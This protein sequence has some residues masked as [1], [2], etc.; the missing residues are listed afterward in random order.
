MSSTAKKTGKITAKIKHT[1][2]GKPPRIRPEL[3]PG[4]AIYGRFADREYVMI[5]VEDF[6]EWY[7]DTVDGAVA[8]YIERLEEPGIPEENMLAKVRR[9]KSVI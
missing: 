6:G 2:A 8:D 4:T 9:A 5:P 1:P 3:L 7:E